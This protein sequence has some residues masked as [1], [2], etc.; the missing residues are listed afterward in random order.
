VGGKRKKPEP[1]FKAK[2]EPRQKPIESAAEYPEPAWII[3]VSSL[4]DKMLQE[5]Q[6]VQ[7]VMDSVLIARSWKFEDT[8]ASSQPHRGVP[9]TVVFGRS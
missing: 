3:F 8:P 5:R 1:T 2:S 4:I 7:R 9:L 6:A